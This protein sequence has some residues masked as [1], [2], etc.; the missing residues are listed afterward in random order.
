MKKIK[1]LKKQ[2][3][4]TLVELLVV[5]A[6]LAVLA[7]ISVVG[8]T[9]FISKANDSNAL[10]E[11]KQA[12]EIVLSELISVTS[13]TSSSEIENHVTFT[14]DGGTGKIKIEKAAGVADGTDITAQFKNKFSDAENLKGSFYLYD[15]YI[16][17]V[18]SNEQGFAKWA[19][20]MNPETG[21]DNS[22]KESLK[23]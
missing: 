5:I 18:T 9:S 13:A 16:V 17:Y 21:V 20:L 15:G 23:G 12:E 7:T 6:I 22:I 2:N 11:C 10:T 14:Y 4:F 1:E 19:S 3:G 8:Y